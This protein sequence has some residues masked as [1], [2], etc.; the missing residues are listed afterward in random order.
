MMALVIYIYTYIY[1][2]QKG[3]KVLMHIKYH[4]GN[5]LA[6]WNRSQ[7]IE[8]CWQK[9]YLKKKH[10][11]FLINIQEFSF[12][13]MHLEMSSAHGQDMIC[14]NTCC[15]LCSALHIYDVIMGAMTSQINGVSIVWPAVCS[16][17]DH[18]NHQSS[19]W[20]AF[21]R[22]NHRWPVDSPHKGTVTRKMFPFDDVILF[23]MIWYIMR[24][25]VWT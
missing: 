12:K 13:E 18:R 24:K 5:I 4:N 22:G 16:G 11:V 15:I 8:T 19:A 9:S 21:V 1:L 25:I 2:K 3:K 20:L 7:T 23:D 17:A 10:E 6:M 14:Y